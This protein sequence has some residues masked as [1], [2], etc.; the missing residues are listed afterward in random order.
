[1]FHQEFGDAGI[2]GLRAALLQILFNVL[3]G[4]LHIANNQRAQGFPLRPGRL[5]LSE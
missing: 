2:P 3:H 5:A 1:M 4:G